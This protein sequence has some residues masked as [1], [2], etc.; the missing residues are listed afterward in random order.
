MGSRT[1]LEGWR[2][3]QPRARSMRSSPTEAEARLWQRLRRGRLGVRFRRQ[4]VIG[5]FI[6]DFFCPS[7]GLVVEVDGPIHEGRREIDQERDEA[8]R[9]T[10]VRVM[11]VTNE[12]V[13]GDLDS[14]VRAIGAAL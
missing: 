6:V 11:R 8:L 13:L 14:V 9:A 7:A 4:V 2:L 5:R 12:D 10:G 1:D 3:L